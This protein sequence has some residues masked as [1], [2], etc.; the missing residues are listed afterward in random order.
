MLKNRS[1]TRVVSNPRIVVLNN[2]SANIQVGNDVPLPTFERNETTG[3]VEISGFTFREVG[4]VLNV[5]PHINSANE[6]LV[7]LQPEI[8]SRGDSITFGT[9]SIPSFNVTKA[10]TQ[11]LIR[12]GETIAI[13]GL[14]TDAT[15]TNESRVPFLGD[16]P[17]VGKFFAPNDKRLEMVIKKLKPYFL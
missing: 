13:G 5:T 9:F 10:V 12:S 1:N 14:M 15:T 7:D 11:V 8:S 3:S 4:V 16:I 2:Q 6:I 17:L